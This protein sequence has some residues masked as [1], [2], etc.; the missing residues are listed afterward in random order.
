MNAPRIGTIVFRCSQETFVS[1]DAVQTSAFVEPVL[2]ICKQIDSVTRKLLCSLLREFGSTIVSLPVSLCLSLCLLI[3]I[4]IE[5]NSENKKF[6][7]IQERITLREYIEFLFLLRETF[8]ICASSNKFARRIDAECFLQD[9]AFSRRAFESVARSRAF[10]I[11]LLR[12]AACYLM[13][14]F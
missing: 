4:F 6:T 5:L 13:F 11:F 12:Y 1:R 2:Y 8:C 10:V 9:A 3:Y 14:A 7:K